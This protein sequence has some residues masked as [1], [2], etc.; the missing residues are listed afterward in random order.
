MALGSNSADSSSPL[1]LEQ[2]E[3]LFSEAIAA[4]KQKQ[5]RA[6]CATLQRLLQGASSR[7]YQL[8]ARMGL[9]KALAGAGDFTAAI[10]Q[11]Q[12]LQQSPDSQAQAW[13]KRTLPDLVQSQAASFAPSGVEDLSG[14]VPLQPDTANPSAKAGLPSLQK[15]PRLRH[16]SPQKPIST[17][18]PPSDPSP[19][20]QADSSADADTVTARGSLFQYQQLNAATGLS[21]STP[22]AS[23]PSPPKTPQSTPEASV[24]ATDPPPAPAAPLPLPERLRSPQALPVTKP[25]GLWL[26]S[27]A[28]AIAWVWLLTALLH[29]FTL[30]INGGLM[31]IRWPVNPRPLLIFYRSHPLAVALVCAG[32]VVASPWLFDRL[33]QHLH[34][35]RPFSTKELANYSHESVLLLRRVCRQRDWLMPSLKLLPTTAP[36][37]FSY[38]FIPRY[39]RLVISQG[40][41][42]QFSEA[43]LAVL[44]A[45][46]LARMGRWDWPILSGLTLTLQGFHMGYEWLAQRGDRQ[47]VPAYRH[48]IG[49]AAT[50]CYGLYWLV[51]KLGLGLARLGTDKSDRAATALTGNPNSLV[52]LLLKT[53]QITATHIEEQQQVPPLLERLDL[54][55][56][57]SYQFAIS[58][59]SFAAV[60]PW[61]EI[62]SWDVHNIYR[63]WLTFNQSQP[64]LGERIQKLTQI[65]E[66]WGLQ[67]TPIDRLHEPAASLKIRNFSDFW[68]YWHPLVRQGSPL[69]GL[70]VAAVI[71]LSLWFV[72]GI[73]SAFNI[74][75]LD[76]LYQ[77]QSLLQGSLLMGLGI[78]TLLRINPLFP[79]IKTALR[80]QNLDLPALYKQTQLL[81][82]DSVGMTLKGQLL[83]RPGLLNAIGQNL[84]LK[85]ELGL[86]QLHFSTAFGPLGYL[87][88]PSQRHPASFVQ[89]PVQVMGW[90]RRGGLIWCDVEHIQIQTGKAISGQ[91]PVFAT[92]LSLV[93][94]LAGIYIIFSGG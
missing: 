68:R 25:V 33:L 77:D 79:D 21:P 26:L 81:P 8:K 41:L 29:R 70:L 86:V 28:T 51:R 5:Y 3:A 94:T 18:P 32:L 84:I 56:P 75:Q 58:Q 17:P 66:Q 16:S 82:I 57:L 78:G 43:E 73:A 60:L 1:S 90:F 2:Q 48:L 34:G 19:T 30:T 55:T 52:S 24:A 62:L 6:A 39:G 54:L 27:A 23:P 37:S 83:G 10:A 67:T 64:L 53:A 85:T 9:V 14:F 38:G 31:W 92:W 20:H 93:A 61:A 69:A 13:A 89:R 40:A 4:L 36:L 59:G 80:Q 46:E 88:V 45:R 71:A 42:E 47:T 7:R 12:K 11:C 22:T 44:Y 65:A 15:P 35:L 72:G 87:F 49:I 50:I 74:W 63:H 76:W 91:A